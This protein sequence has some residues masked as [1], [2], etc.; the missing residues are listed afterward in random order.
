MGK[1]FYNKR[2][3][4]RP[5]NTYIDKSD[6][7]VLGKFFDETGKVKRRTIGVAATD[8][9]MY[10]NE[11]FQQKYPNLWRMYYG[12]KDFKDYELSIGLYSLTLG[13]AHTTTLYDLLHDVYGESSVN[14]LLDYAMYSML[15]RSNTTQLYPQRMRK[16]VLFSEKLYSDSWYSSFFKD[17][18]NENQNHEFRL[19]WLSH[20]RDIGITEAWL[21]IDG[22]NNDCEVSSSPLC[23]QGNSKSHGH[24]DI[25]GYMYAV[26]AENG[27][28]ITY[29]VY[30]GSK[31]DCAAFHQIALILSG[32]GIKTKGVILDSGFCTDGVLE[33]LSACQLEYIVMMHGNHFGHTEMLHS[34]G[35]SIRWD[36]R[37]AVSDDGVFGTCDY[38]QLFKSHPRKGFVN[39]YFDGVRGSMQSIELTKQIR[40][41]K[42]RVD[43]LLEKGRAA[44]V[45]PAFSKYVRIEEC[46]DKRLISS[47]DYDR[48]KKDADEK[49][50]FS[51]T[52]SSD[53]GAE[54]VLSVYRLRDASETAYSLLKSQE[55]FHTTRVHAT[56]GI[57]NKFAVGF[58]TS[59]IRTEIEISCQ[60]LQLDTNEMIH[61]LD[62]IH[63]FLAP[64]NEYM[65][66]KSLRQD[67][68]KLFQRYGINGQNLEALAGEINLRMD[69]TYRNR[70]RD[71]PGAEKTCHLIQSTEPDKDSRKADNIEQEP[72]KESS[73]SPQPERKRPGRKKGSKDSYQR[74]RRTKAEIQNDL[75]LRRNEKI[76]N[77]N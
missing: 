59:I 3:I 44:T 49:G 4:P 23:E 68:E 17:G 53:M 65:F 47:Y 55:G 64:G 19:Q 24:S 34:H 9:S 7:R 11:L 50:F 25:A 33:T 18:F 74:K 73:V 31:P 77:S 14:Y 61:R 2:A 41:E 58:I 75:K 62:H 1:V 67:Q 56:P 20:C 51:I 13:I 5:D 6:G 15:D 52:S 26:S 22:S 72:A 71:I 45:K 46:G 37:N 38:V 54:N 16:E 43:G 35:G 10:P 28:P 32:A 76:K 39:L 70:Y 57:L 30:E 21:C 60:S 48:W 69:G 36:P 8:T 66:S 42:R 40:S 12:D 63:V 27:Y 29:Y